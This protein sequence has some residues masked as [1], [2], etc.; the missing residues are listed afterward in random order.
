MVSYVAFFLPF[1]YGHSTRNARAAKERSMSIGRTISLLAWAAIAAWAS[2]PATAATFSTDGDRLAISGSIRDGDAV[3]F[4]I[5]I[6]DDVRIVELSSTG[7]FIGEAMAIGRAIR[8]R[9][10]DTTV[11]AGASCESA[12]VLV[13]SAGWHRTVGGR[14][15]THCATAISAPYQCVPVARERML[16]YLKEMH[17]PAGVIM[18]QEAAGSTSTLWVERAQLAADEGVVED[19]GPGPAPRR[20]PPPRYHEPPLA[21]PVYGPPPGMLIEPWTGR[22]IPCALT[23]LTFGMLPVC[24]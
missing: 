4:Q 14:L 15:G 18:L 3:V 10:L 9:R 21:P 11:P 13:W 20:R 23:V 5:Q 7:G 19:D 1:M 17:A 2:S 8:E 6:N 12:C 22:T 16:T 24:I